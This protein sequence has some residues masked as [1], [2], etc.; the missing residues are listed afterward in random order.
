ME[1]IELKELFGH[2][3]NNFAKLVLIIFSCLLVG[4]IYMVFFQKPLYTSSTTLVLTGVESGESTITTND[5]TINSKLVTTYREI[6]K[7]RKILEQVISTLSLD[8][9]VDSLANSIY[10]SSVSE[11]E[12]IRISVTTE[13]PSKSKA[14]ADTLASVFSKEIQVIYNVKNV[15]ILDEANFST[16]PSNINR[17]KQIIIYTGIGVILAVLYLCLT[18]Y[19]DTTIK[20]VEQIEQKVA[21]PILGSVPNYTKKRRK[22]A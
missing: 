1:E 17:P 2:F 5:L 4:C 9:T 13:S 22:K 18:F 7:S 10:V 8:E 11:T 16:V 15:S 20:S 12:I 21:L 19:F 14:I 3:K 6:A